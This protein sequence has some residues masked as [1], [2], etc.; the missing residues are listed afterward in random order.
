ML[1]DAIRQSTLLEH[2]QSKTHLLTQPMSLQ[3]WLR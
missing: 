3:R 1:I 2:A